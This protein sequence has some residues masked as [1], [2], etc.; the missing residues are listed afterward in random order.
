MRM[1]VMQLAASRTQRAVNDL[2]AAARS[3]QPDKL[4]WIPMGEA[5]TILDQLTEC[6]IANIKWTNIL[7]TRQYDNVSPEVWEQTTTACDTLPNILAKLQQSGTELVAA[8]SGI[9]EEETG[10]EIPTPWGPYSLA[11][12]CLHAYWNMVYHE[13]QINYVQTLYGDT[14]EHY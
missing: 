7:R 2:V 4:E 1:T 5:R 3:T 10:D 13:G 11:D 9:P 14:E 8:I 6:V 12:C